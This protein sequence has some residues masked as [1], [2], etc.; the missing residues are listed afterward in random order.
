MDALNRTV[1]V[2]LAQ[3]FGE[4]CIWLLAINRLLGRIGQSTRK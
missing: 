3:L 2:L 1:F 4:D